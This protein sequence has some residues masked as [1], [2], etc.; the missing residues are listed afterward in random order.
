MKAKD[1][2]WRATLALKTGWSREIIQAITTKEEAEVYRKAGLY[3]GRVNGHPVLKNPIVDSQLNADNCSSTWY[4]EEHPSY[5]GVKSKYLT[6][7]F[8]KN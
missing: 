2:F 6:N 5:R 4:G 3:E 7:N 1:F 8:Q